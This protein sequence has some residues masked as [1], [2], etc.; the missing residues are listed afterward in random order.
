MKKF[1]C[2]SPAQVRCADV[3]GRKIEGAGIWSV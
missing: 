2:Q 3:T 1:I